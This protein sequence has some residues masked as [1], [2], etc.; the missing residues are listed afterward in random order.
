MLSAN[1]ALLVPNTTKK[2]MD[3]PAF[4]K[5]LAY[6]IDTKKIVE[7][8][9]GNLVKAAGPTGLLPQWDKYVDQAVVERAGLHVRHREGEEAAGRR[10]LQGHATA[11]GSW[12]TRT[13]PRSS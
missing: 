8:V 7:G 1:T 11:T 4:R 9:Y 13:A 12:R 10:R 2:P 5:A 3:D 6:S